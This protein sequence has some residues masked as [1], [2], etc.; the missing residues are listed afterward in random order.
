MH[1]G[2]PVQK[3]KFKAILAYLREVAQNSFRYDSTGGDQLTAEL[4]DDLSISEL[5]S[6]ICT[7]IVL[8]FLVECMF[9]YIF[10]DKSEIFWCFVRNSDNQVALEASEVRLDYWF[11]QGSKLT[12]GIADEGLNTREDGFPP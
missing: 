2:E 11:G 8:E 6:T 1:F 7:A 12:I 5:G 4:M 9:I 10:T 3:G